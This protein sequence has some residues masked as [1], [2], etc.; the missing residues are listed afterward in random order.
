MTDLLDAA[1]GHPRGLLGR[2]GGLIMRRGNAEEER[3][4]VALAAVR[5]GETVLVVG[6]GPGVGLAEASRAAGRAGRVIGVDPSATM[7][8]MA[9]QSSM[10]AQVRDGTAERTGCAESEV[11]AVVS[12]NNVMLWDLEAGLAELHRVLKPGGRLVI[13]AHRHVL[14]QSFVELARS[15]EAA[16]FEILRLHSRERRVNSDAVAI[17][18][19][20]PQAAE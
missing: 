5:P 3:R 17:L 11:D 19:V 13:A 1:F 4:A 14:R 8:E 10:S 6:P 16:G 12:V 20:K 18:S 9:A 7:R 15:V 2:L